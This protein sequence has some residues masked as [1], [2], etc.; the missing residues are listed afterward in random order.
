MHYAH[1]HIDCVY[2]HSYVRVCKQA[3]LLMLWALPAPVVGVTMVLLQQTRTSRG[4]HQQQVL[5]QAR[6]TLPVG[7][8][9]AMRLGFQLLA[10]YALLHCIQVS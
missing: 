2:I 4:L 5:V 9:R 6:S 7:A 1:R 10:R 3:L 8:R